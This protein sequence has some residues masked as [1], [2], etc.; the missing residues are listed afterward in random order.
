VKPE[1][2]SGRRVL[3][4][5]HTGFKGSWLSLWLQRAG[6]DLTGYALEPPTVPSLYE[7]AS[8]GKGMRSVHGD[9]RDLAT[10]Q[11]VVAEQSPEV[12]IHMAAQSVVRRSYREPVETY[13]TNVMGTVHV[14]E[15]VR[16]ALAATPCA[17]VVVT[18]DKCYAP[19]EGAVAPPHTEADPMGG[20][21]PYSNSKGCAE[22]VAAAYRDSYDM[23][24]ATVRAGNAI[25]GGDWTEDQ[26]I[27]DLVS[28][29]QAGRPA[30]LRNPAAVR[31]WQFVLEPLAGY[32]R[33]AERLLQNDPSAATSWNFGPNG[34]EVRPVSWIA[35]RIAGLW[36]NGAGWQ[37]DPKDG[38][39]HE[40]AC[41]RLDTS[42]A[43]DEL[44]WAP[45][46]SIDTSLEWIVDWYRGFHQGTDAAELTL[47]DIQRYEELSRVAS[48][49]HLSAPAD[50]TA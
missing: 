14:L 45:L 36:G 11:R 2:W 21:D 24:V 1:L 5:G 46:L 43:Q 26:L 44:G 37:L 6:A 33:V 50:L 28:A 39:P 7:A 17:I 19:R 13:S 42:K 9:V 31:P 38:Q 47:R 25:G 4:T 3:L 40:T 49:Q 29:A 48:V 41:L 18:S 12:V 16:C 30:L 20:Y 34:R 8:V 27:P 35:D 32:M 23:N 10:L 15:A 22:L